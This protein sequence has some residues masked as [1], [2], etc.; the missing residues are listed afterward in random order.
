MK[1]FLCLLMCAVLLTGCSSKKQEEI[2]YYEP[3]SEEAVV[4]ESSYE[5]TTVE[6]IFGEDIFASEEAVS[7]DDPESMSP[8][9]VIDRVVTALNSGCKMTQSPVGINTS[10]A[11]VGDAAKIEIGLSKIYLDNDYVYVIESDDKMYK[12]SVG[13]YKS[14]ASGIANNVSIGSVQEVKAGIKEI[15]I[16][17]GTPSMTEDS[18]KYSVEYNK[19]NET[20]YGTVT[21]DKGVFSYIKIPYDSQYETTIEPCNDDIVGEIINLDATEVSAG[22]IAEM[23]YSAILVGAVMSSPQVEA[24]V[25]DSVNEFEHSI[26]AITGITEEN[27]SDLDD[28]DIYSYN[29]YVKFCNEYGMEQKYSYEDKYYLVCSVVQDSPFSLIVE[30][31]KYEGDTISATIAWDYVNSPGG[32]SANALVVVLDEEPTGQSVVKHSVSN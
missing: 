20:Y 27:R 7:F 18:N 22:E 28:S 31:L 25:D 13:E 11:V 6:D 26:V 29:K 21:F 5:E 2:E 3:V 4:E 24:D 12:S 10:I 8:T 14:V 23:I 1:K 32:L 17:L 16:S 15:I 9:E 30:D 19:D